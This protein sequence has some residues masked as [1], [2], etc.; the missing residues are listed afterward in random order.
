MKT[1]IITL[2]EFNARSGKNWDKDNDCRFVGIIPG[3]VCGFNVECEK[4]GVISSGSCCFTNDFDDIRNPNVCKDWNELGIS[5]DMLNMN[6][7]KATGNLVFRGYYIEHYDWREGEEYF[8]NASESV[9]N[10]WNKY[11][12]SE[13]R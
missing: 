6:G 2:D 4:D 1:N 8:T 3:Y 12:I 7:W 9:M 13:E 5:E 11:V 10:L